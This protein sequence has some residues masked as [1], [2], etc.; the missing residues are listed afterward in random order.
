M[1]P[2]ELRLELERLK[3]TQ[4]DLA[5]LTK[6]N[7]RTVRRWVDTR[8]LEPLAPGA[9]ARIELALA[10]RKRLRSIN[11]AK[12]TRMVDKDAVAID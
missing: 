8:S 12:L 11:K 1:T 9:A 10:E 7:G 6:T 4:A 5:R 2:H 3:L